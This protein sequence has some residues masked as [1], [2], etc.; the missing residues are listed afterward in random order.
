MSRGPSADRAL[1]YDRMVRDADWDAATNP[2]ETSRRLGVLFE[3]VFAGVPLRDARLLDAGSGGGH[4]SEEARRRGARVTSLDLGRNPLALATRRAG[5]RGVLGSTL[6]LPFASR[7]FD[8]VLSTEVIEHTPDPLAALT[9][10]C[11]A[12]RPGG[13]LTLTTPCRLWQPVVRAASR[14]GLRQY[15]GYEN[16]VW[17]GRARATLERA[18]LRVARCFGFNL[19][20]LFHPAL[21]P[22]HRLADAAGATLPSLFVNFAILGRRA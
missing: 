17:P 4:F 2:H 6:A 20:P 19:I 21:E 5:T 1:Y 7:S 16:F 15:A 8:V 9:E 18:G 13:H 3:T 10:L 14:T 12:V 11:R 22:L